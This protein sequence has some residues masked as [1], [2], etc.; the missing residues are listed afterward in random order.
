MNISLPK[1]D[2]RAH[3]TFRK[4]PKHLNSEQ[5]NLVSAVMNYKAGINAFYTG[6]SCKKK[7]KKNPPSFVSLLCVLHGMLPSGFHCC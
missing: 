7:K 5:K 4:D 6:L 3:I 2:G 1:L